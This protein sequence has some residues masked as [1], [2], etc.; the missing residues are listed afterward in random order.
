MFELLVI[1][2]TPR[3]SPR[4]ESVRSALESRGQMS[5]HFER[6]ESLASGLDRLATATFDAILLG[7]DR[8][9]THAVEAVQQLRSKFPE[10]PIFLL[11][12]AD[13]S[14]AADDV[15]RAGAQDCLLLNELDPQLLL[16]ALQFGIEHKRME[17]ALLGA[18]EKFAALLHASADSVTI[19]TWSE[20]RFV[21]FNDAFFRLSG[22][23]REEAIGKTSLDLNLWV[24]RADRM[25]MLARLR[26]YAHLHELEV[27]FRTKSGEIRECRFTA[28]L[29]N[30][31]GVHCI[32]AVTR[33][34]TESKRLHRLAKH[35]HRSEALGRL[36]G[37]LVHDLNNWLAV[38]LGHCELVL[39]KMSPGDPMR[40]NVVHIKS[41][42]A[43]AES[44][45]ERLLAIGSERSSPPQIIDL[46]LTVARVGKMLRRVLRENIDVVVRLDS[47]PKLV[48]VLPAQM[49][50]ALLNLALNSRDA[51]PDGGKLALATS[52]LEIDETNAA[53]YPGAADGT[54][55]LLT[56]SDTGSGMDANTLAHVFD[57]FFTTK[58]PGR[59][60]GLG[61]CSVQ[62]FVRQS[63][64]FIRAESEPGKGATFRIVFPASGEHADASAAAPL[65]HLDFAC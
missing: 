58:P 30:L 42:V 41:A 39:G 32:L 19:T 25:K 59:G 57:E 62:D 60:T 33:D 45:T 28:E 56:V 23:S 63:G 24:N 29:I 34:V 11:T 53:L 64:G 20:G 2:Q 15:L 10:I 43:S 21:E 1:D 65:A 38:I 7:T 12:A 37:G 5:F 4:L 52:K 54:Y 44:L 55:A 8:I 61:L 14:G 47:A 3:R 26:A 27:Q 51:M 9:D 31:A 48:K 46:N 13:T 36:A 16:R 6:S 49:E 40:S 17:T 50:H 22:Y 35:A 18:S